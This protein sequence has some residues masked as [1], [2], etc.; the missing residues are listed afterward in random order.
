[1]KG[2]Q[3]VRASIVVLGTLLAVAFIGCS[4]SRNTAEPHSAPVAKNTGTS[5]NE[6]SLDHYLNG[7]MFDQKEEYASAILEYQ[8]ALQ[9]EKDPAIY[10]A[11]SKDYS[12]LGKHTLAI[13]NGREA[14]RLNPD[15]RAYHEN[16]AE[17]YVHAFEWDSAIREYEEIIRADSDYQEAW[18][19]VAR[20]YQIRSPAKAL[21]VYQS[22]IDRFG[23]SWDAYLQ[24]AQMYTGLGKFDK[25]IDALKGL[26]TLDPTNFEV[27]K[28]L[29]DTYL[30]EDSVDAALALYGE[31]IERHPEDFLVRASL[32][33]AYLA[34][35]DYDDAK[36]QF[37]IVLKKDTLTAD[38]QIQFGQVFAS[39]I[40]KDSAVA[41]IARDLF[42]S[43]QQS[44]PN[45]WRPC[46]FLGAIANAVHDDSSALLNFGRVTKLASWN[47]DG[48]IGVASIWFDRND[49]QQ[50]LHVLDEAKHYIPNEFRLY[51]LL[52]LS[53][54]RLHQGIEAADALEHAVQLNE[55]S[56]D[57]LASLALVYDEMKRIEES[58]STYERALRIDPHNHLVLNNYGYS[59]ADRGL[60][61]QRAVK[62]VKEALD[63]QPNNTSYLDSM[64]WVYFRF[65]QY[66][67]AER[68]IRKAVELG[69][70]SAVI[71]EHMGD[72][73]SKL[74][75]K[76]KA[77]E[78]WKKALELDAGNS[79]LKEKIER[80]SL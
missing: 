23:P 33:H 36:Q 73:Y 61:L 25:A 52:G 7:L 68:F 72:V 64:G 75:Q 74:D 51:F 20:L 67:E 46:M 11:L 3:R 55:K 80:G 38:Q 54:Q 59:L 40:Q 24:T 12:V 37:E 29:A 48:W 65:G 32:A 22:I 71:H 2:K 13:Q 8:D 4:G 41:P 50:T 19:N 28:T 17:I 77:I 44:Y 70:T 69:T 6:L 18:Y 21:E 31:L 27:K 35:R 15:N 39:F 43:I 57:A 58:D 47:A 16:L 10:F 62:M 1:M 56:V 76:E 63:Q 79:T 42:I 45:D 14:L 78:S 49:F 66:E 5:V 60:Q 53:Y 26:L 9:Y 30:R 34:K